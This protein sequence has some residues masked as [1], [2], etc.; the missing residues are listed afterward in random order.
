MSIDVDGGVGPTLSL[1][2]LCYFLVLV[3]Y[4]VWLFFYI[5]LFKPHKLDAYKTK[6]AVPF[7]Q[8]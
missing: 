6:K 3:F 2:L 7:F 5:M 8:L 4:H 1:F